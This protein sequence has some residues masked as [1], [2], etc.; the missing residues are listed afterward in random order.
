[1]RGSPPAT[2]SHRFRGARAGPAR[3]HSALAPVAWPGPCIAIASRAGFP[4]WE[5]SGRP[6][7]HKVPRGRW[8]A[9]V[10]CGC[11]RPLRR[12]PRR[13]R[14]T[15][16]RIPGRH[17]TAGRNLRCSVYKRSSMDVHSRARGALH[18][19]ALTARQVAGGWMCVDWRSA[20][21]CCIGCRC[22]RTTSRVGERSGRRRPLAPSESRSIRWTCRRSESRLPS[23]GSER[24]GD[25]RCG[26]GT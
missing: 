6:G 16:W 10:L 25:M 8:R 23:Q 3:T 21:R 7:R 9:P 22:R 13:P 26:H 24:S 2:R 15:C 19:P 20:S 4:R 17:G 5:C 11:V 1:V 14:V 12:P 18:A